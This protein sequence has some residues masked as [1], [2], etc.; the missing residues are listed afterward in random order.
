VKLSGAFLKDML[1]GLNRERFKER[2]KRLR[3]RLKG[4]IN[5]TV[6]ANLIRE[7]RTGR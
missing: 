3:Q 6:I 5:P 4:R 7:D 1:R 2:L